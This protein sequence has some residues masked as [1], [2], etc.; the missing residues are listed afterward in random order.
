MTILADRPKDIARNV[1]AIGI[2]FEGDVLQIEL[3][4]GR[5]ISLP[6]HRF[7]WLRWLAA[8]TDQQRNRWHLEPGGFALY[9]DD[10]DDGIEIRHL[11]DLQPL[12]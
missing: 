1:R 2:R 7:S 9:W 11:L 3:A 10:L 12:M 4:D 5:L 8:A 6:L